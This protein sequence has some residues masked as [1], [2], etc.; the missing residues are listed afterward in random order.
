MK[1]TSLPWVKYQLADDPKIYGDNALKYIITT[2][3]GNTEICG[4]FQ[5]EEDA[6][7]VINVINNHDRL[8]N[9][10][11]NISTIPCLTEMMGRGVSK[12][13]PCYCASCQAKEA[14]A[15]A[16]AE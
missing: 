1:H 5:K 16:E 7:F 3:D 11:K 2:S 12:D 13:N 8:L 15:K 14:V 4:P 10:L 6:D 9:A